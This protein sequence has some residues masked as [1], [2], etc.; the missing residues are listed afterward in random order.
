ME[1]LKTRTDPQIKRICKSLGISTRGYQRPKMIQMIESL[2][3]IPS[4]LRNMKRKRSSDDV[5]AAKK[6]QRSWRSF[7]NRKKN[8]VNDCDFLTLEPI[9]VQPF[10]LVEE[11]RHVYRFHPQNLVTYFLKEGNF[12]NPYTRNP[13]NS[14]EL[15]RLDKMVRKYMPT[16]VCLV[17]AQKLITKQRADER[18]HQRVCLL[19]HDECALLVDRL[20]NTAN[21]GRRTAMEYALFRLERHWLPHFFDMFRQLFIFD[22]SFACDSIVAILKELHKLYNNVGFAHNRQK[23]HLLEVTIASLQTFVT[24]VLPIMATMLPE[25]RQIQDQVMV[26]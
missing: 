2:M 10:C 24:N 19:M 13:L 8:Y 17:D 26:R 9:E 7:R 22:H 25:L 6:I 15:H 14:V 4:R 23:C 20:V 12:V 16:C 1:D 18:E 3:D 21:L 5:D 11:T